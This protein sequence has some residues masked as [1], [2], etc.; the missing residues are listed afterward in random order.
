MEVTIPLDTQVWFVFCGNGSQ[1]PGMGAS[2]LE[3]SQAFY[4]SIQH[5][6]AILRPLDIDLMALFTA[7]DGW[8]VTTNASVGLTALQIALVD[9]LR[10]DYG[11][12]PDGVLGHSAGINLND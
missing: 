2:L 9:M 7:E 5:S 4:Q 6:A 1:W 10:S 12:N 3:S 11:I 8:S